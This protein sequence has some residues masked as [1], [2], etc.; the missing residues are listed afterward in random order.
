MVKRA[1]PFSFAPGFAPID[2]FTLETSSNKI[3]TTTVPEAVPS[4]IKLEIRT[5]L[6][7]MKISS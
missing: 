5:I 2:S 6:L 4:T 7:S 1:D 3:G